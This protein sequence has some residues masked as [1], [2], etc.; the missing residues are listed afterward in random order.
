[1]KRLYISVDARSLDPNTIWESVAH[2]SIY[3][4]GAYIKLNR[5]SSDVPFDG[6]SL[7][8]LD[9]AGAHQLE[10]DFFGLNCRLVD[11]KYRY[12]LIPGGQHLKILHITANGGGLL[13]QAPKF[14]CWWPGF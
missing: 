2:Q 7:R 1:M 10:L 4:E 3:T 14:I 6:I 5:T 12:H 13:S 8:W 9:T 11:A